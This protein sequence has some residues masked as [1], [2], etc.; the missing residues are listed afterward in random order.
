MA[1][2]RHYS[3]DDC[4]RDE[5]GKQLEKAGQV[6]TYYASGN[7]HVLRACIGPCCITKERFDRFK[8]LPCHCHGLIVE[9]TCKLRDKQ[10]KSCRKVYIKGNAIGWYQIADP[11]VRATTPAKETE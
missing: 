4:E 9:C 7:G 8:L 2:Q 1:R 11:H 3:A 5:A 10:C 6:L